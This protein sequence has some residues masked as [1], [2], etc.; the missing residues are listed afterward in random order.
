[1]AYPTPKDLDS[2]RK[3]KI[4]KYMWVVKA[5]AKQLA[6]RL[7]EKSKIK[8]EDLLA[9]GYIA[10]TK[11]M[12]NLYKSEKHIRDLYIEKEDDLR[13]GPF[14]MKGLKTPV[15]QGSD[16]GSVKYIKGAMWDLLRS[17]DPVPKDKRALMKKVNKFV[18]QEETTKGEKPD[19][20]TIVKKL[21]ISK[22]KLKSLNS[23][24]YSEVSYKDESDMRINKI[25]SL[26][27]TLKSK[28]ESEASGLFE[29]LMAMYYSE[30]FGM[31][32]DDT[33]Y[34]KYNRQ[35]SNTLKSELFS[36]LR[37][38]ISSNKVN[39]EERYVIELSLFYSIDFRTLSKLMGK[40]A[41][42]LEEVFGN[43]IS[44]IKEPLFKYLEE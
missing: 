1:M 32:E 44:K 7:P 11:Q 26:E 23:Y 13:V 21:K 10:L 28:N 22:E 9:E 2:K 5:L 41:K 27:L 20:D 16:P 34:K 24:K 37:K 40:S 43:G 18:N 36:V 14:F 42:K 29:S 12:N 31:N 8:E 15:I 25:D 17:A 6:S 3:A 39:D 30:E 4:K 35:L 33:K 19:E 38:E